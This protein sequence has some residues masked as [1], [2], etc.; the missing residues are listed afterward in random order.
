[1]RKA[2]AR[3]WYCERGDHARCIYRDTCACA[4]PDYVVSYDGVSV[5]V[6]RCPF[7]NDKTEVMGVDYSDVA[8]MRER[9]RLCTTHY[10]EQ[11]RIR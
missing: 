8:M 6:V 9:G 3:C 11:E 7:C 1:M 4:H 2:D 5:A 10:A